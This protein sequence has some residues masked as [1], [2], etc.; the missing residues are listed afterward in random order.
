MTIS[1][2]V[3]WQMTHPPFQ[4]L[5]KTPRDYKL[6]YHTWEFKSFDETP[7]E[8]WYI[9]AR[10]NGYNNEPRFKTIVFAH[11]YGGNRLEFLVPS[12][13][14]V[15]KLVHE[16]YDVFLF[17][18]RRSGDSGGNETSGGQYEKEDL[19]AAIKKVKVHYPDHKI[20]VIGFSMGASAA[21]L[22]ASESQEIRA[23]VVDSPF[24]RMEDFLSERFKHI[25]G[26]PYIPYGWITVNI[27]PSFV[28]MD[29]KQMDPLTQIKKIAPRPILIVHG[30]PDTFIPYE[31][32][33]ELYKQANNTNAM[34]WLVPD[35]DH[36]M[37]YRKHFREYQR[38]VLA[39][40]G[41]M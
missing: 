29:I 11:S 8:G 26:L 18:F 36:M 1:A 12:M 40:F 39:I 3:G 37:T 20:G 19:L 13:H 21:I 28:G 34:L 25:T 31:H 17:D 30:L 9:P 38:R 35:A 24:A 27:M 4:K 7:L 15:K 14:L 2:Y 33:L 32:S 16:G 6:Y 10:L 22:A 5:S 23:L 41:S